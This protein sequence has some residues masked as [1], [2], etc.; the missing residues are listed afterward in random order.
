[1]RLL[2]LVLV[3]SA[4]FTARG[5]GDCRC[6]LTIT[7]SGTYSQ[8][9][10][11]I[12]PG[13]TVCI[14]AGQY[15]NLYF[16]NF[17][18]TATKPIRFVNCGGQVTLES[19][20]LP[21]GLLFFG[22]QYFLV[23]GSGAEGI[24]YG[25]RVDGTAPN[26]QAVAVG[27][28]SSDCEIERVEVAGAGFA[29]IMVKTDPAACDTTTWRANFVMRNVKIHD[30]YIHDVGGEG[31]YIGN[32]FWGSGMNLTCN[33]VPVTVF[34]HAILGLDIHHNLVERTGAEGIQYGCSPEAKVHHNEVRNTGIS[35]FALYQDNGVQIGSGAGG[36][37]Y[38]NRVTDVRGTG[39]QLIGTLGDV[40]VYNNVVMNTG[41][42]SIFCDDRIGSS[43]NT[44]MAFLNNTL[45]NSGQEAIKLYNEINTNL[46]AN[47]VIV[48]IGTGRR[49]ILLQQGAK[50]SQ[51][52]NFTTAYADSAGFVNASEGDFR[53]KVTSPLVDAGAELTSNRVPYD[54]EGNLRPF[55][56]R[57]DIGAYEFYPEL[58]QAL[59][60][61]PS[62]CTDQISV[63]AK[64]SL[65]RVA[66][67][68]LAGAE[69][70]RVEG[71]VTKGVTLPVGKLPAGLYIVR[72]ETATGPLSGRFLKQ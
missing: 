23:S 62:P 2:V 38:N 18:G 57:M 30:N 61:Y 16:Q 49:Y 50:A 10:T 64:V 22:C 1:M 20:K 68:S 43:A 71:V 7:K 34:P 13:Q 40:S 3:V 31:M 54:L 35:P 15:S 24:R 48:G 11:G 32:S 44:S 14:Q 21:S 47:N 65:E 6:D 51:L 12:Q 17:V 72:A 8:Q 37:F 36:S 9:A 42:N 53:L 25:I 58:I 63:L 5:Q 41:T 33:G 66:V 55:G 29:G 19:T 52:G 39:I 46:I 70:V 45:I 27:A 59:T 69:L 28:K 67:Y 56:R 60:L 4:A 26:A